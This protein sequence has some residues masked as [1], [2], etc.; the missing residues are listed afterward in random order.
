LSDEH[1]SFKWV[2][3]DEGKNKLLWN[4]QAKGMIEFKNLLLPNNSIKRS[5]L[6]IDLN[7]L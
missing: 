1:V 6:E 2:S 7:L 3:I 4:N 5:L